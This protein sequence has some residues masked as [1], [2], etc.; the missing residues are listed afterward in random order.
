VFRKWHTNGVMS[1]LVEFVADK[2]EGTSTA[3]FPSGYLKARVIL[4]DGKPV[5]QKFWQDGEYKE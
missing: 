2:P 4:K 3:W 5:E 1:E